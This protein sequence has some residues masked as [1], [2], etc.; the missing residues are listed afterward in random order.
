MPVDAATHPETARPSRRALIGGAL[1]AA[2][3][4]MGLTATPAFAASSLDV[5][6]GEL[7]VDAYDLRNDGDQ[8]TP[9]PLYWSG[10]HIGW[11]SPPSGMTTG[12]ISYTVT[13]LKPDGTSEMLATAT[14]V[15]VLGQTEIKPITWGEKGAP[16]IPRGTYTVILTVTG[17]GGSVSDSSAET[18]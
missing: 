13:L 3:L 5:P 16:A 6:I 1:W 10:G 11:W 2:P 8:P 12:T 9:G 17:K 7:Q 4:I 14:R 15:I 18:V